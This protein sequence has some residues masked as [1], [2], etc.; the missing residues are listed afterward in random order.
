VTVCRSQADVQPGVNVTNYEMLAHFDPSAFGGVVLDESG[1]LKNFMG[2]T[3][4]ALLEAFR[5]T[6]YKLCCTATPA[7][8]DHL[9]LGNHADFLGVM[10][11]N[12][13]LARWFINDQAQAGNYRLK[14]HAKADYWRWVSSWAV[15]LTKPSDLGYS[16]EGFILPPLDI[17]THVV[18]VDLTTDTDGKL[19]RSPDL[20]STGIHK[21]K[22]RTLKARAGLVAE[23]VRQSVLAYGGEDGNE[24]NEIREAQN[25][26]A[27]VDPE[28]Q[29]K[30][31]GLSADDSGAAQLSTAGAVCEQPCASAKGSRRRKGVASEKPRQTESATDQT[32]RPDNRGIRSLA[33]GAG[34]G[35]QDLRLLGQ[36]QSELLS[37]GR[38]LS[39]DG[40]GARAVVRQLQP[41]TGEVQGQS[42][43]A[44][45]SGELP[46]KWVVWCDRNDE[47]D[48]LAKALGPLCVSI[49]GTT[50]AQKKIELE[51][52]WREGEVPVLI[53]KSSVFGFGL[54]WQHCAQMVFVGSDYSFEKRYQAIRRIWR[55]GQKHPCKVH[56]I[57]AE[58]ELPVLETIERKRAD[59]EEM[60]REMQA[61]MS[62]TQLAEL[63]A[64]KLRETVD[65][66][67]ATGKGWELHLGDSC[68]T[69][70]RLDD[71]SVHYGL[72]SPPFSGLYIYSDA[73]QDLGNCDSHE[74]FF[75]HYRFVIRELFRTAVP[76]SIHSIHCK[77]LPLYK[78]RD[79]AA[80]LYDFPGDCI[81]AFEAEGWTFHSRV[82][83]WKS[84]VTEMQRTKN[85]GLLYKNLR[86][87]SRGSRSGMADYVLSFRKWEGETPF[88]EPVTHTHEGFALDQWQEWASPVWMDINQMDVLNVQ[89]ARADRDEKHICPIQLGLVERLLVLYSRPGDLVLSPFAGIGSE[90]YQAV[91]LGR[92]FWGCELKRSYWEQACRNLRSAEMSGTQLSLSDLFDLERAA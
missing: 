49:Q 50:L 24:R 53:S 41:R 2:K 8:N 81:R 86:A 47:Q 60:K 36:E 23:L 59:H 30:D 45:E 13:M 32:I 66:D 76:G 71:N 44:G 68:E 25:L 15:S 7:P 84:P 9:E 1:I 77:D 12:E 82:T 56:V 35:V 27:R 22:R 57:C 78:G 16:D 63:G 21:E 5:G 28:E 69:L 88:P 51:R 52:L 75:E 11:A 26:H 19:F 58:T 92:R 17:F 65:E 48:A 3:K 31:C 83:I 18:E 10:P 46:N 20:S 34:W 54:N 62:E 72:H 67:H 61:A 4:Q 43:P 42:G 39:S 40:A 90:G 55:F 80:G 74:E 70:K 37:D 14:G 91:K 79:G 64:R 38:P 87:D 29:G 89:A 73:L 85:H 33:T 6:P